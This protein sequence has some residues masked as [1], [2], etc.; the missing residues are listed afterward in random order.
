MKKKTT[1]CEYCQT[2]SE[3]PFNKRR[4]EISISGKKSNHYRLCP[5]IKEE[6]EA[7]TDG[8]KQFRLTNWFWCRRYNN[9]INI[10]VCIEKVGKEEGHLR[11]KQGVLVKW[12][13]Q[14]RKK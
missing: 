13:Y 5:I 2:W 1:K 11:C 8:C 9:R 14:T 6:V 12:I 3:I 7:K 10:N 4:T